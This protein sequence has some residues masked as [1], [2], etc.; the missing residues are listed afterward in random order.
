MSQECRM[1][2]WQLFFASF[3]FQPKII[4]IPHCN[5]VSMHEKKMLSIQKI[6]TV[7]TIVY[8]STSLKCAIKNAM[9]KNI[10]LYQ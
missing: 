3:I 1:I 8:K 2:I 5:L 9:K 7:W 10:K 6:S 4:G